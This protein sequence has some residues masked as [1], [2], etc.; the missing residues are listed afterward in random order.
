LG[1]EKIE[2]TI[3]VGVYNGESNNLKE[4]EVKKAHLLNSFWDE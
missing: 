1:D 2:G 4:V 3:K